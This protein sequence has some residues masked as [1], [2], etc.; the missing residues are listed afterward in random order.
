MEIQN[1]KVKSNHLTN[2][3]T[4]KGRMACRKSN[5]MWFNQTFSPNVNF[6]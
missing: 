2:N 6:I 1:N 5:L 3:Y 4:I